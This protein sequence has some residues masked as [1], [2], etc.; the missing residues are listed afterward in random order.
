MNSNQNIEK[1]KSKTTGYKRSNFPRT[2][3]GTCEKVAY[4]TKSQARSEA[5]IVNKKNNDSLT[6]YHCNKCG[7]YHLGHEKKENQK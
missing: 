7:N 4:F 1:I 2:L 6:V 5:G 3:I